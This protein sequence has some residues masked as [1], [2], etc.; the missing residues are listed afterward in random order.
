M[1]G[2]HKKSSFYLKSGNSPLFKH[3]GASPVKQEVRNLTK[4]EIKSKMKMG[5]PPLVGRKNILKHLRSGYS[6]AGDFLHKMHHGTL[7]D[8]VQ[9]VAE[10]V[11]TAAIG[12]G[13]YKGIA[14]PVGESFSKRRRQEDRKKRSTG[15]NLIK[16]DKEDALGPEDM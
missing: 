12:Y 6:K 1:P 4:Q 9:F 5:Y 11:S 16:T 3:L 10:S 14:K 13:Y 15:E 8:P 7:S 2:K